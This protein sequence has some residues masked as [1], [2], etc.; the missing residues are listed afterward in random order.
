VALT[1]RPTEIQPTIITQHTRAFIVMGTS[2]GINQ[3]SY[4]SATTTSGLETSHSQWSSNSRIQSAGG[5]AKA[6][7]TFRRPPHFPCASTQRK[8]RV[9]VRNLV[10]GI[11]PDALKKMPAPAVFEFDIPASV[12]FD[13]MLHGEAR[14]VSTINAQSP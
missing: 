9:R 3:P 10:S 13:N 7:L 6:I 2:Q 4:Y 11:E 12:L 5:S 14:S 8:Y 1:S